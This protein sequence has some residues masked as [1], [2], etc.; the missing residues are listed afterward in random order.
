GETVT[1]RPGERIPV[2][3][4]VTGGAS[5]VDESAL[6]GESLPVEKTVG[7]VVLTGTLNQYGALCVSA[8]KVGA[9]TTLAKVIQLVAEA[10]RQKT[11]LERTA[12]RL[13]RLF[14]PFVL[15]A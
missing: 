3:G 14:L 11:P 13:A 10:T 4:V 2:D 12:D 15:G 1:I 6:T 7:A 8:N 9:E 5:S